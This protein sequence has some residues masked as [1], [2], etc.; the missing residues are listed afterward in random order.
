MRIVFVLSATG[1]VGTHTTFRRRMAWT[2]QPGKSCVSLLSGLSRCGRG[3]RPGPYFPVSADAGADVVPGLVEPPEFGGDV[4]AVDRRHGRVGVARALDH[5][6]D[7][8]L[9][10]VDALGLEA[11]RQQSDEL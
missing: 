8:D 11:R 4:G 3:C 1:K 6:G 9:A 7:R 5:A 10:D 2:A